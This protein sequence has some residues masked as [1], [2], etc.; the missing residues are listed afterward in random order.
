LA[1]LEGQ[2]L[3]AKFSRSDLAYLDHVTFGRS[4]PWL[5][6]ENVLGMS[7]DGIFLY[8]VGV[9]TVA[10]QNWDIFA[11]KFDK[12]LNQLWYR[13]WGGEDLE[14]ARAI[15]VADDGHIYV[16]GNT[17]SFGAGGQDAVVLSY[18]P[19]GELLGYRTWGGAEEDVALDLVAEGNDL[20]VTGRS[21]SLHPGTTWAAYLMKVSM[22]SIVTSVRSEPVISG[23]SLQQN[24]P[25][26]FNP[27]TIIEYRLPRAAHVTLRIYNSMGQEVHT[28]VDAVK[29]PAVY[30]IEWDGKNSRGRS[31]GT[32][33]YV[34]RMEAGEFV[35]SKKI[36]FLR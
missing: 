15:T 35:S 33:L 24:Y 14:S 30:K 13:L 31:V 5:N 26:P 21:A 4:D 12:N 23:F 19:E 27:T 28:L 9:T 10:A 2:A 34:L 1:V 20:Y 18:S 7:S 8:L 36:I 25:N 16:G 29:Q 6:F 17:Q 22:D 32:G 3:V 11:A